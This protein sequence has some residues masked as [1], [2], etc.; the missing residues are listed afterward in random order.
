MKILKDIFYSSLAILGFFILGILIYIAT[1]VIVDSARLFYDGLVAVITIILVSYPGICLVY[2][3][4]PQWVESVG[5]QTMFTA[6]FGAAMLV[7]SFHITLPTIIDR[8]ISLFV[9]SRMEGSTAG[10]T[11]EQMQESFLKG[12]VHD[13]SAVCRR[14]DEQIISGNIEFRD[15]KYY[16]GESGEHILTMLRWIARLVQRNEY[17]IT[18]KN[19]EKLL[20]TYT[21]ENGQCVAQ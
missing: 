7:Y 9:L 18:D 15:Q 16:L 20:Y 8:S 13:Y 12:Y 17:Y 5:R 4:R 11:V 2:R 3:Y 19:S 14:L 21:V 6:A 10:V 1:L